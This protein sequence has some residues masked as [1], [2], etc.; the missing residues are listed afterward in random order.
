VVEADQPPAEE[1]PPGA[2]R[3]TFEYDGEDV[4]VVAQERV[5]MLAPPDDE[6]LLDQ[7]ESGYW[8]EIRDDENAVVYR[9]VIHNPIQTDLEVFPEDP[10]EPIRRVAAARPQGVFQVVVPDLPEGRTAVLHGQASRQQL[11]EQPPKPM[12]QFRLEEK[13]P[14][15]RYEQ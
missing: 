8:V 2:W 13:R 12:A 15:P 9:Q 4:R 14:P 11:R 7:G 6:Q 3:L 5:A 1:E 10:S